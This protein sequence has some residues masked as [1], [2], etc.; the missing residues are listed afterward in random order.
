MFVILVIIR[1]FNSVS[2]KDVFVSSYSDKENNYY[3][4]V[5]SEIDKDSK[6]VVF[7][8]NYQ[9]DR[10]ARYHY[11]TRPIK[12]TGDCDKSCITSDEK[13]LKN[14]N[15]DYL[16]VDAGNDIKV[17]GKKLKNKTFYRLKSNKLIEM[18]R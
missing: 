4:S 14:K 8:Y 18:K 7:S 3:R 16:Y 1:L 5:I 11:L 13:V 6:I 15:Y 10:Y 2:I 9:R 17:D 12:L